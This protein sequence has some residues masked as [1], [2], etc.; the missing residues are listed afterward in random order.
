MTALKNL[1]AVL[2]LILILSISSVGCLPSNESNHDQTPVVSVSPEQQEEINNAYAEENLPHTNGVDEEPIN[3]EPTAGS[4]KSNNVIENNQM[5]TPISSE[6]QENTDLS[7][8]QQSSSDQ[9]V[10]PKDSTGVKEISARDLNEMIASSTNLVI[11]DI[12][13]PGEYQEGHIEGSLLGDLRLMRTQPEQYLD[14]LGIN[15]SDT[16]V[17]T[18]ETGNKSYMVAKLLLGTEYRNV[19]NLAGGKIDWVR[20]GYDLVAGD[21]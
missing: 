3:S 11:I 2:F 15:K 16:I 19:Y 20:A 17:L 6:Q 9:A 13:T 10:T 7:S 4:I 18:C 1:C 21:S 8:S 5:Q 14:S 12:S